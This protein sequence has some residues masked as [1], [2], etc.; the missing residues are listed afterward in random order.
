M[1]HV[2]YKKCSIFF[3]VGT[4]EFYLYPYNVNMSPLEQYDC[5]S[6]TETYL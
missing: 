2:D 1:N 5:I 6:G 3:V 4:G